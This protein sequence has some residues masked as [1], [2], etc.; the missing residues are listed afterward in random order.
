MKKCVVHLP[1]EID[2]Q[3]NIK[4]LK[5]TFTDLYVYKGVH[6]PKC[7]DT[8]KSLSYRDILRKSKYSFIDRILICDD[9]TVIET[10]TINWI[11]CIESLPKN[12][13]ILIGHEVKESEPFNDAIKK[14]NVIEDIKFALF[15]KSMFNLALLHCPECE[16]ITTKNLGKFL[17]KFELNVYCCKNPFVSNARRQNTKT[18]IQADRYAVVE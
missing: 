4:Q 6:V 3:E 2:R 5:F 18:H 12:W 17:N 9:D 11:R 15:S 1:S 7:K 16:H 8:G 14:V 13:D 10:E